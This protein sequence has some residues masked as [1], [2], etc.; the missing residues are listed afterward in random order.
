MHPQQIKAEIWMKGSNLTEIAIDAGLSECAC[1]IA[2]LFD[3]APRADQA[4][5]EFLEK[6]LH[7]LWPHRY[8]EKN[9]RIKATSIRGEKPTKKPGRRHCQNGEAA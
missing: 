8:D 7:A 4:I 1:R 9:K 2:L 5:A 3:R 6:D